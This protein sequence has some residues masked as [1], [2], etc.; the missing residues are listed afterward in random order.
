MVLAVQKFPSL[1]E[2]PSR[3][4]RASHTFVLSLHTPSVQSVV[5][6]EQSRGPPP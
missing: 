3:R 6:A 1:H 5:D 4:G 2:S